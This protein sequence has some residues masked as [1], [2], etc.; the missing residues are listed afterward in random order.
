MMKSVGYSTHIMGK[1]HMGAN[2][3]DGPNH[4][5]FDTS[6]GSIPG[7]V[8]MYDHHYRKG[9]YYQAWHRH[10]EMISGSENGIH[11]TDLIAADA[12]GV[13]NQPH[14]KPFF[15]MI[16][17]H[18]P[19]TPLDERGSFTD[20]PTQLDP[21]NP[22]RWMNE[23]QIEWFNDPK[24]LIQRESDPEKRLLL[25]AVNHVDHAI[26]QVVKALDESG[27]RENTLILYSSD[28][29]PQ[30]SW[31]GHAYP[32]DLKLT[33]FNQPL[34]MR[35]TKCD[36]YEGGI[37][38]PGVANWP[39]RISPKTITDQD[40]IIDWFPTLGKLVGADVPDALDGTD[41]SPVLCDDGALNQRDLYWIWNPKINRWALRFGDWKIVKYGMEEPGAPADWEL[42]N[43]KADPK[44]KN[45]VALQHP[46]KRSALPFGS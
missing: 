8:G 10:E 15:M 7:A 9:K 5:G 18:A 23:D 20:Q 43:L 36:V 44:E 21:A 12:V 2:P 35:G 14:E 24:G 22:T 4:H 29:G 25:A 17:F 39:C 3:G 33:N 45:N 40:H 1:W 31:G 6:Y 26:G 30:M 28:N 37:H 41:L 11:V 34:P 32:N 38:V 13:I 46:E 16:T 42:Y 27:Q 19:H